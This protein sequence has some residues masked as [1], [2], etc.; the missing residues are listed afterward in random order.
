[1]LS[2]QKSEAEVKEIQKICEEIKNL[3]DTLFN[4][5][6]EKKTKQAD[7]QNKI[8]V[9]ETALRQATSNVNSALKTGIKL[10]K[11]SS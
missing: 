8:D 6:N 3:Y 7:L 11:T 2:Y 10:R 5:I 1:M 4:T 9:Q